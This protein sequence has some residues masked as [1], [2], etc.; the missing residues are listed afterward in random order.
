MKRK[1]DN[2]QYIGKFLKKDYINF[3]DGLFELL[4]DYKRKSERLDKIIKQS[5]KMQL[6]LLEANE[7][8]DEYKNNLE[9]KVEEEIKKREEKEKMLI[10]QSKFAAMGEMI[11]AIAHQ[12]AQP[13]GILNLKLS[14]L[15][16]DFQSSKIDEEYIK[17]FQEK[18]TDIIEHMNTTLNEFRTFFRPNKEQKYFNV[19]EMIEK[20]FLFVKDEFIKF[21]IHTKLEILDDFELMGIE[22]EF[23]HIILNIINNSKDAFVEKNLENREIFIKVYEENDEKIIE[24]SDNAGGID[25]NI[26]NDIFKA[27]FTTKKDKGSGIGLYMSYQ[28]AKKNNTEL[29]AKNIENGALFTLKKR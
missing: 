12:W 11:D 27:N 4:D 13:L 3:K 22:N 29:T 21:K 19:K 26:I 15:D 8:L 14:M 17:E 2:T 16:F 7:Q 24:I 20:V 1:N 25:K 10:E 9:K 18:A 6:R 23:K 28:I 5:D